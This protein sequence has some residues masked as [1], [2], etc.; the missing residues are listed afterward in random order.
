MAASSDE[1]DE[2][3]T[4]MENASAEGDDGVDVEAF[5]DA[6]FEAIDERSDQIA[7]LVKAAHFQVGVDDE[8]SSE[9]QQAVRRFVLECQEE[10][11]HVGTVEI[12]DA[13]WSELLVIERQFFADDDDAEP[14]DD[15][16]AESTDDE[17][18]RDHQ[19]RLD[20]LAPMAGGESDE[21]D[22]GENGETAS[23]EPSSASH[24]PAFQ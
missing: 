13:L 24:D 3:G 5:L 23:S 12:I 18:D 10:N 15:S 19:A 16:D 2:D 4:E 1:N 21:D 22:D 17:R 7:E 20:E 11:E 14:Q 9:L 6:Q 8:A